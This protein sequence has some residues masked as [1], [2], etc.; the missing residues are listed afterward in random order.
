MCRHERLETHLDPVMGRIWV[1]SC[2]DCAD[3]TAQIIGVGMTCD[4]SMRRFWDQDMNTLEA[5]HG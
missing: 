5:E 4:E 3:G 1:T 2:Y